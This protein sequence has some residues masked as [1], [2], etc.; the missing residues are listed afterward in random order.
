MSQIGPDMPDNRMSGLTLQEAARRLGITPE[1][2]RKRLQ[3]GQIKGY[4]AAG[5]WHVLLDDADI[6]DKP[7]E[8][9]VKPSGELVVVLKEEVAYLREE[10]R[11]EREAH[12]RELLALTSRLPMLPTG[13]AEAAEPQQRRWRWPWQR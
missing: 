2:V 3:R 8:P 1:G 4:R 5:R 12:S 11:R 7:P 6:P 13:R 10:L 9:E